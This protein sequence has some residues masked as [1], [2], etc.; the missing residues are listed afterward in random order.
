M[1]NDRLESEISS[2]SPCTLEAASSIISYGALSV[3]RSSSVPSPPPPSSSRPSAPPW[4]QLSRPRPP[5]SLPSPHLRL[6]YP[7][8]TFPSL[9]ETRILHVDDTFVVVDKPAG[10]PSQP[11]AGNSRETLARCVMGEMSSL[12]AGSVPSASPPPHPDDS[13]EEQGQ[14]EGLP[15]LLNR[16]DLCVSGVVVFSRTPLGRRV[17]DD[18]NSR[19]AVKKEYLALSRNRLETGVKKVLMCTASGQGRLPTGGKGKV[20]LR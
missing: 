6:L 2:P 3:S 15:R 9:P 5:E 17:W 16:V 4:Y 20:L 1:V 11:Y 10:V 19:K 13:P 14:D 12:N 8:R 18:M 7:V